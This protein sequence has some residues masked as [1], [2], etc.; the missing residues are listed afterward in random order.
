MIKE[1]DIAERVETTTNA[2]LL[3][4]AISKQIVWNQLDY[5]RVSIYGVRSAKTP[6]PDKFGNENH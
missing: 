4:R 1:A 3:T 2:S 5:M 6:V